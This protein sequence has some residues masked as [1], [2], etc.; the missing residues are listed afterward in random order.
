M[1]TRCLLAAAILFVALPATASEAKKR[2]HG[3]TA[4]G[5]E[6]RIVVGNDGR[7]QRMDI[8][9]RA[10]NCRRRGT[11]FHNET[12]FRPLRRRASVDA[13]AVGG[14]YV[15]RDR[16]GIRS[17]VRVSARGTRTVDPANPEAEQWSGSFRARVT[18]R[19]GGRVL[20]RCR[21]DTTWSA[22]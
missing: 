7:V 15:A 4:Q 3:E 1:L 12:I 5:R 2:F 8:S 18:V 6:V 22:R 10:V 9:W 17:R 13:F 21:L 14:S 19:R 20:D 11:S 16:G